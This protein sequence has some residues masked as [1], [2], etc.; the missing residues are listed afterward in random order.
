MQIA[1]HLFL[2][3]ILI[4]QGTHKAD[5]NHVNKVKRGVFDSLL[6]PDRAAIKQK[7]EI[8]KRQQKALTKYR[9]ACA[10]TRTFP[11]QSCPPLDE[12]LDEPLEILSGRP[13]DEDADTFLTYHRQ[14]RFL[15][16]SNREIMR[17]TR[18]KAY[19]AYEEKCRG[20]FILRI[21]RACP[22]LNRDKCEQIAAQLPTSQ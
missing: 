4:C 3:I 17:K 20:N 19:E 13:Y 11:L 15:F 22:P 16:N 8:L 10:K 5:D 21:S 9:L 12:C 14:R 1:L 18:R 2:L 6:S 7:H